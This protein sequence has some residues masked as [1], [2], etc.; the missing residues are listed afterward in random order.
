MKNKLINLNKKE[1]NELNNILSNSINKNTNKLNKLKNNIKGGVQEGK[2][3]I[4]GASAIST[5]NPYNVKDFME[6]FGDPQFKTYIVENLSLNRA[7]IEKEY[8]DLQ[9][10]LNASN[11]SVV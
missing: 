7:K 4:G 2:K 11:M 1:L 5:F 9:S 10:Q 8:T 3:S 6:Q